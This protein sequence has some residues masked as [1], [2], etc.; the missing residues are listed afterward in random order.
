MSYINSVLFNLHSLQDDYKI[1]AVYR[2]TVFQ[3]FNNKRFKFGNEISAH[4]RILSNSTG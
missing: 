1:K 3:G 4:I 2:E